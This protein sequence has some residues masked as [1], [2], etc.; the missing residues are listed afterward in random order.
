MK[1]LLSPMIAATLAASFDV[2]TPMP[3]NAAPVYVPNATEARTDVEPTDP[4]VKAF[5]DVAAGGF[6]RPQ[7]AE[8]GNYWGPFGDAIT[9]VV[10]GTASA[11]DAVKTACETMNK[12]NGKQFYLAQQRG[13]LS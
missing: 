5:A 7:S 11:A 4:Q 8:F 12:A 3:A 9:A 13:A 2:A 6:P 1:T 10:S